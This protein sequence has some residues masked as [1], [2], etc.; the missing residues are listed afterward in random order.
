MLYSKVYFVVKPNEKIE[1]LTRKPNAEENP[2]SI[3][4]YCHVG[5]LKEQ[6]DQKEK[7]RGVIR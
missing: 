2:T 1:K 5:T 7:S 6:F 4:C 3:Y